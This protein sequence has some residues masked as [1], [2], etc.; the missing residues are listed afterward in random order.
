[1]TWDQPPP[2]LCPSPTGITEAQY[3]DCFQ[4]IKLS[5]NLLV[6]GPHQ[7]PIPLPHPPPSAL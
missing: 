5:F 7:F 2:P 6:C 4:K 3:I 1:M